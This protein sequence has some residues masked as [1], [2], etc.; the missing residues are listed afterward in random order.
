MNFA[1]PDA[2]KGTLGDS[3]KKVRPTGFFGV[4]RVW[5]KIHEKMTAAAATSTGM[6]KNI[7]VWAKSIGKQNWMATQLPA[8]GSRS[9]PSAP[10]LYGL[11]NKLVFQT[12][13]ERLGLDRCLFFISG[14][15]PITKDTL[16]FFGSLDMPIVEVY[17]M[18]ECTGPATI[19]TPDYFRIG[20]V[21]A[22]IPGVELKIDHD[23]NRDKPGHGEICYRGRNVMMGYMSNG[24]KTTE[25]IDKEGWLHSG[26]V[27]HLD[28]FGLLSI[29]GRIKELIITAGGE[30]IA[31]VPIE[32]GVK[33]QIPGI[34]NIMMVGDKRKYN[35]CLVTL[36]SE[37]DT[38]TGRF[39]NKLTGSSLG[40][41]DSKAT[42]TQ[43]A[44]ACPQWKKYITDGIVAC[45][46]QAVSNAQK[47]Q[48]FHI[49]DEDFSDPSGDL[50][51][52]LKLKRSKVAE[53]YH[54]EIESLYA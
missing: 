43:E 21:G 20:T 8:E 33:A 1:R 10:M 23:A 22:A 34:A 44:R 12:V 25:A 50:T 14:A 27:G 51:P 17:G 26:D 39:T 31:P 13:K 16:T 9:K 18:S 28:E 40:V 46:A 32:E 42:T 3:L 47:I 41:N 30:N 6:K 11:A 24:P 29:T 4:P 45:N 48:K 7:G 54:D 36:F 5:E 52:T 37:L 53:K 35:V 2:L 38:E 15:A 49:L 19:G